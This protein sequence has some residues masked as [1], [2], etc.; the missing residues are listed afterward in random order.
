VQITAA[1]GKPKRKA[2]KGGVEG[3]N[4]VPTVW[5]GGD[6]N[7]TSTAA[8]DNAVAALHRM[9][10]KSEQKPEYQLVSKVGNPPHEV[11]TYECSLGSAQATG[12]GPSKK[13]AK[14]TA[15]EM[16]LK[17]FPSILA[18]PVANTGSRIAAAI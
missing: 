12:N 16:F 3:E 1:A 8:A 5:P 2:K 4:G 11:F 14:R 9:Y 10:I 17:K 18:A 6:N 13:E 7:G 15:A